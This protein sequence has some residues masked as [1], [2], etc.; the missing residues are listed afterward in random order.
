[1]NRKNDELYKILKCLLFTAQ[2]NTTL[3]KAKIGRHKYFK[4]ITTLILFCDTF[5]YLHLLDEGLCYVFST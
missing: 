5:A 2:R 3:C 1:M 4:L